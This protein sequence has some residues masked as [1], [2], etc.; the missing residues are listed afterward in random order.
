[1]FAFLV[2]VHGIKGNGKTDYVFY[3]DMFR[4]VKSH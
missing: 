2:Q 1:M 3:Y 4:Y